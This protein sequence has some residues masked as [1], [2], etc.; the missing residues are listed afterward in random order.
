MTSAIQSAGL[1]KSYG[2][3]SLGAG[4][5]IALHPTTLAIPAGSLY[6]LL[7]HNGA[8]KTTL[9]KLLMNIFHPS[10]GSATVLGQS[11]SSLG[12]DAFARIG[13]VSENQELPGW[14]TVRAFLSYQSGFYPQWDDAALIRRFDLPLNRKLKNLSRGQRMKVALASVLA[15][16]PSLIVLDEP[17]SG[18]DPLVRDE[19]IEA[20]LDTAAL[21]AAPAK[22]GA[23]PTDPLTILL[24]SHD[25]A[26]I[27]SFCT[28]VAF[29][30]DG[31]LLFAEEMPTLSA[32]F[33]E[34]T[35]TL[36][37]MQRS[38]SV[39][40]RSQEEQKE[41]EA[42]T[43][44]FPPTWLL[45]KLSAHAFRFVHTQADTEPIA[46]QVRAILP[47][48]TDIALEPMSLRAIFLAIA[49]SGRTVD[50]NPSEGSR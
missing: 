10:S 17:F 34:V 37:Q 28:H 44:K 50:S 24:S 45:P 39:T 43:S 22:D 21:K 20:L 3:P 41:F 30:H 12:A 48:A 29:L 25:L 5:T 26:E 13:Y 19:L 49:K 36:P 11:S 31:R 8:G 1:A 14:M 4:Q 15:F 2:L 38:I 40:S 35:V 27:E 47:S 7:G 33:R 32:R 46:D 9:L 42:T 23:P 18:L 6:A 16:Q